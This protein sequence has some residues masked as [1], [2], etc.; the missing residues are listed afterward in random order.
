MNKANAAEQGMSTAASTTNSDD[1]S[2]KPKEGQEQ[3]GMSQ[4]PM[5]SGATGETLMGEVAGLLRSLRIH[6][7][8][9]LAN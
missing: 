5:M 9:E 2:Q 4:A 3:E 8:L 1:G 6:L 7:I